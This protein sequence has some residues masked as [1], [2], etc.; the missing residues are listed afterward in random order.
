MVHE[1]FPFVHRIFLLRVPWV[2]IDVIFLDFGKAFDSVHYVL[3]LH[4][5][6]VLMHGSQSVLEEF[7]QSASVSV[8]SG[9]QGCILGPLLFIFIYYT[10]SQHQRPFSS[11]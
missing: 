9:V 1:H 5:L 8:S 7:E 4:M 3:L 2:K 10:I 11:T 6:N